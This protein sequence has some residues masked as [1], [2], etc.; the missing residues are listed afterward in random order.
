MAVHDRRG[1]ALLVVIGAL[2]LL[3]LI[4][5]GFTMA[6][7]T[8]TRI[9]HNFVESAR[10]RAL[11]E[12]GVA[13][14]IAGLL[15]LSPSTRWRADGSSHMLDFGGGKIRVTVQD[16]AGKLDLNWAPPEQLGRL[17]GV[18]GIGDETPGLVA[19]VTDRR[20]AVPRPKEWLPAGMAAGQS[21][22]LRRNASA[23]RSVD[24]LRQ[25]ARID[26]ATFE[27]LRPYVTVYGQSPTVN[28]D[29]AA[30]PVLLAVSNADPSV[31]D[32]FLAVR[33]TAAASTTSLAGGDLGVGGLRAVTIIADA[34]TPGGARFVRTAVVALTGEA[35]QP[36]QYL[37]WREELPA[38]P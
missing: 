5:T 34:V 21:V 17:V 10:A 24:E 38:P 30:R 12:A 2:A 11:A 25:V 9:A 8:E 37:E 16:E 20:R 32:A 4:V 18:L 28:L 13:E 29:T 14:A 3:A 15:D 1:F 27:R 33:G 6:A 23:F 19:A 7:R 31:V 26:R 36:Y 22:L 35:S